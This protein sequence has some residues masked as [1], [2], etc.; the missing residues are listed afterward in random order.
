MSVVLFLAAV[1]AVT[2]AEAQQARPEQAETVSWPSMLC[3]GTP[4]NGM[5]ARCVSKVYHSGYW[6]DRFIA[7]PHWMGF[8]RQHL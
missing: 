4:T 5:L 6:K 7:V 2:L 1:L 8:F 3:A